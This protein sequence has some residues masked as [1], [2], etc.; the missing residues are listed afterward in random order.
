MIV[1]G[2]SDGTIKDGADD[3]TKLGTGVNEGTKEGLKSEGET[4]GNFD[5]LALGF[6]VGVLDGL[7]EGRFV[8]ISVG[9]AVGAGDNNGIIG[10]SVGVNEDDDCGNNDKGAN[11]LPL[12]ELGIGNAL[13]FAWLGLSDTVDAL[14]G[15]GAVEECAIDGKILRLEGAVEGTRGWQ[16]DG[17]KVITTVGID[18]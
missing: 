12:I 7:K 18:D 8:G 10:K 16:L 5:G 6:C 1:D 9:N 11:G 3:D 13:G 4:D 2:A 14:T 15:D 17:E